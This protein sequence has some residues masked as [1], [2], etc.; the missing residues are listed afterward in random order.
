MPMQD[1]W[2]LLQDREGLTVPG[3]LRH[4]IFSHVDSRTEID[5]VRRQHRNHHRTL[6]LLADHYEQQDQR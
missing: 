2:A 4:N 1:T 3:V 5:V 6:C